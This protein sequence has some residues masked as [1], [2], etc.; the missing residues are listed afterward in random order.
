MKNDPKMLL[1]TRKSRGAVAAGVT[2]LIFGRCNCRE[3]GLCEGVGP[4]G[5]LSSTFLQYVTCDPL[6]LY[7]TISWPQTSGSINLWYNVVY[8]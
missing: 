3:G 2:L 5:W 8:I 6:A 1:R 4:L 7:I